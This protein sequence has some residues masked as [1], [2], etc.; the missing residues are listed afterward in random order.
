[1][2]HYIDAIK[3]A[4]FIAISFLVV[5]LVM[6]APAQHEEPAAYDINPCHTLEK[7]IFDKLYKEED[8]R[9]QFVK[10]IKEKME[11]QLWEDKTT[12]LLAKQIGP[13]IL[14]CEAWLGTFRY[15]AIPSF[16][17]KKK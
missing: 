3:V 17:K 10:T 9:I 5:T 1:M 7:G 13:Q 8:T 15:G 6:P 12:C 16:P 11:C 14:A 4:V 2:E